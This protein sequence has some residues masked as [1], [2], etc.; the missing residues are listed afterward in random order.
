MR[1]NHF[2]SG[3]LP[4]VNTQPCD[5]DFLRIRLCSAIPLSLQSYECPFKWIQ[6][7]PRY[8]ISLAEL[9]HGI[10]ILEAQFRDESREIYDELSTL[11]NKKSTFVGISLIA[12][13]ITQAHFNIELQ[14]YMQAKQ[15]L[16][17][18]ETF[19]LQWAENNPNPEYSQGFQYILEGLYVFLDIQVSTASPTSAGG[20][21]VR[22]SGGGGG[23]SSSTTPAHCLEGL[24]H[25]RRLPA[26]AK[27]IVWTCRDVFLVYCSRANV[28]R[29]DW[30]EAV[31]AK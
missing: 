24:K 16:G 18:A 9:G 17:E 2:H 12:K 11:L 14:R 1:P 27:Y 15:C 5:N 31:G 7:H 29:T 25:F 21:F 4:E 6:S 8:T 30:M 28:Q 23:S 26:K 19:L 13:K 20:S 10:L 3:L 22:R